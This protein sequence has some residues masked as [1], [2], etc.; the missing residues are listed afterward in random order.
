V[1]KDGEELVSYGVGSEN[2]YFASQQPD[3]LDGDDDFA[4][5]DGDDNFGVD[6][7]DGG[8]V[9]DVLYILLP[10]E[11]TE[12]GSY[13]VVIPDGFFSYEETALNGFELSYGVREYSDNLADYVTSVY[14]EEGE[15][16][17]D[18]D[19]GLYM[20]YIG[21]NCDKIEKNLACAS[22]VTLSDSEGKVL[23]SLEATSSSVFLG[24]NA[25]VAYNKMRRVEEAEDGVDDSFGGFGEEEGDDNFG[26]SEE[27]DYIY[28]S[29]YGWDEA[30]TAAGNYVVTIPDGFFKVVG[31]ELKGMT[32][33]YNIGGAEIGGV[34]S[35]TVDASSLSVY[36]IDG[37][38]QSV[39]SLSELNKGLYIVNGK[40]VL[41]RK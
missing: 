25:G 19:L 40:K 15:I 14:P 8:E 5:V 30:L 24:S 29:W 20:T 33:N 31:K 2:V 3:L 23:V 6:A 38:R 18:A 36:S 16:D 22:P 13:Q 4:G 10:K 21:L 28:V 7:E 34:S 27:V 37:I 12:V 1:S 41:V 26:V 17:L 9:T 11:Y 35:L 32:L 39:N